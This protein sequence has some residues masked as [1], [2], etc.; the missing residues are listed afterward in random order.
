MG[1]RSI[2]LPNRLLSWPKVLLLCLFL[3]VLSEVASAS[4][5]LTVRNFGREVYSGGPQNWAMAQDSIGRVYVGNRDG[6]LQFDGQRWKTFYLKNY[7]TVRSLMY[8]KRNDRIYASGY[9]EFGYFSPDSI[10]GNLVYT[11]LTDR[12]VG[13][14]PM[15]SE[16]WN[17]FQDE[18]RVYFQSD[19]HIFCYEDGKIYVSPAPGR[20]SRS[21]LVGNMVIV[22]LD[23]GTMLRLDAGGFRKLPGTE[24]LRG[25]KI[26]AMLPMEIMGRIL[27]A[28]SVDGLYVYDG[29]AT[30]PF[31]TEVS[32]F[33]KNSQIFCAAYQGDNY[34]IGTVNRGAVIKNVVTNTITYV[35]RENGLQNNTV[36]GAAF[37]K[38]GNLWLCLDNG[39]DYAIYNSPISNLIGAFNPVGAGYASKRRG[40]K[41]YFGT[42]QGLYSSAYPITPSPSPISLKMELKGQI[43]SLTDDG[44]TMFVAGD[45]GGYLEEGGTFAKLAGLGGTYKILPL[46][47]TPDMALASTYD[48]FHL[49]SRN[50]GHWQDLG[51]VDGY[52]DIGGSFVMDN[53][54][55]IWLAHWR[56]GV[57]RLHLDLANRRFDESVLL[58]TVA[59]F[60]HNYN[61]NVAVYKDRVVFSTDAG[62]FRY[63]KKTK[64]IK[65]DEE[66][67]A[68]FPSHPFGALV[69]LPND[70]LMFCEE[71]GISLAKRGLNGRLSLDENSYKALGD[72]IMPGFVDIN[73]VGENELIV[74]NQD[75]FWSIDTNVRPNRRWDPKPFVSAVYTNHDSI[76]YQAPLY[77]KGPQTIELPYNLNALKFEFACP[78]FSMANPAEYSSY[79]EGYDSDWSPYSKESSREYTR[80]SE[81]TYTLHLRIRNL[82]TD[83]VY[84]TEMYLNILPPWYRSIFAKIIYSI[85]AILFVIAC[86]LMM[87]RWL[88]RT[89]HK[90]DERKAK[91][92][93]DLRQHARQEALVKDYEIATLKSEQLEYD[94]KHKVQELSST[95]MNLVRKNEML[96][97]IAMKIAKLQKMADSENVSSSWMR[98]L[99]KIR[100]S[101]DESMEKDD[102][103]QI[104]NQN[105]DI[106]YENFTKRLMELHPGLSAADKRMCCY[107][108]MGLSSKEIAPLLNISYKSVEMARYRL[109]KK[110][111]IEGSM[112]LTDYLA[113]IQ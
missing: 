47:G 111:N 95:T 18:G 72:K 35:N 15:F 67:N 13:K 108:K 19:Y 98:Q 77:D 76:V 8:D 1:K 59:G 88:D 61:N 64:S 93:E 54:G 44:T 36:L 66:L 101:I 32:A 70:I 84:E 30:V 100:E 52:N 51:P 38:A 60:P 17:I 92:L 113:N 79:L 99:S 42:N 5:F 58:D 71:S 94:I 33:L 22:A 78:D 102:E 110:M 69:S 26:M 81:G 65:P 85:L 37:D 23:D 105:F 25:K 4:G 104:I 57:Y 45:N 40:N 2:L 83:K 55:N 21:A 49:L 80:L 29:V 82:H 39:L 10:T 107:I 87:R 24:P 56:K 9:E 75:G 74:S 34:V 86:Y 41:I 89:Q 6:M 27:V 11:T 14:R 12:F 97:E 53:D 106:V 68:V 16:V 112:S 7:T 62:F 46:K 48:H 31:D 3:L 109:R 63:D 91:E 96:H 20:I 90:M 103:W 43:W 28:T 73:Y 50:S